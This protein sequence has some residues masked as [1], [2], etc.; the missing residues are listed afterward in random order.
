MIEKMF[1]HIVPSQYFSKQAEVLEKCGIV[2]PYETQS[3][4]RSMLIHD[5]V[6]KTLLITLLIVLSIFCFV[7]RPEIL[8][9]LPI[10]ILILCLYPVWV[11][12]RVL[13]VVLQK[14][15]QTHKMFLNE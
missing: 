11:L 13:R 14:Q 1:F 6:H 10:L 3:I 5:I 15:M 12:P 9:F 4:L 7:A 8:N 2:D